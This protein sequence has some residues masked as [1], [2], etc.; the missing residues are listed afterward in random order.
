MSD[1][2]KQAAKD[3]AKKEQKRTIMA[4]ITKRKVKQSDLNDGG[5]NE[6]S[7]KEKD[8]RK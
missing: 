4:R 6:Q 7:G 1:K 8:E 3:M 2:N 5:I